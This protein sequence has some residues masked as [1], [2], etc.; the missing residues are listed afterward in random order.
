MKTPI[1]ETFVVLA[2]KKELFKSWYLL[3]NFLWFLAGFR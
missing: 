3:L 2:W 1:L